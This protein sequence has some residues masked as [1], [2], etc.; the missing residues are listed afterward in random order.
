MQSAYASQDPSF[1]LRRIAI[2][3]LA[4]VIHIALIK[5]FMSGLGQSLIE[6]VRVPVEATLIAAVKPP[7]PPPP[8]P[9]SPK[10]PPPKPV[11]VV[12]PP[13]AF[14]PPPE[15][16]VAPPVPAPTI[17][18]ITTEKPA[19]PPPMPTI[20]APPADLPPP[21]PAPK[22]RL[23]SGVQPIYRPP[24]AELLQAY[25]RQARREG[26]GG[27]V[28]LRLTVSPSGDVIQVL[29]RESEPKRIFDRA[30]T[31]YVQKFRFEKGED[32]FE[33]DQTIEFRLE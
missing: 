13:P 15:V 19:E 17:A 18:A 10:T 8:P 21:K 2:L 29:V 16:K 1:R 20:K 11:S 23:R 6:A 28:T 22:P 25:P 24:V 5:A 32:E 26:L 3:I 7:P 9:P 27:R 33:V 4:V 12:P 31:E 30:A 14:V